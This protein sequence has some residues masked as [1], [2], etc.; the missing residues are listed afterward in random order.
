MSKKVTRRTFIK[1]AA[2]A[3][4]VA[5]GLPGLMRPGSLFAAEEG[6]IVRGG[7]WRVA[8]DRTTPS[9]DVH[10]VSE[11]F[12]CIGGMY[13]CLIDTHVD[14]ETQS[15]SLTPMLAEKWEAADDGKR[16]VFQLKKGVL[17]HD[18]SKFTAEVAKWNLDRVRNHP[19]SYL[20]SD[21]KEI[22][23][24]EVLA[25]DLIAVNLKAPSGSLLYNLSTARQWGGMVSKA[26][27]EKH[28]DDE[29]VRK[30][31]G[32]G[33]F[34]YKNW[35]VDE[36]VVLEKFPDYWKT[37]KDGKPLPY[38]DGMEEHYRPQ[39]NQAVV[40]LRAGGLDAVQFPA[41]R[42]V[43]TIKDDPDLKY[44]ELPPFEYQK[45]CCGFNSRRGPFESHALRQAACYAIDREK[46]VKIMG[47]GVARPHQFPWITKGQP[48][49]APSMWPDYSYNPEKA[50]ELLKAAHPKGVT[51]GLFVIAREPDTTLGELLKSMWDSVGIRTELKAIE[52]LQWIETMRQDTYEAGFWNAA[53]YPGGFIRPKLMSGAKGNWGQFKNAEVDALLDK[54]A[55]TLEREKRHELMAKAL[56]IVYTSAELT[57]VYA[58]TQAV[59]CNK[60]VHGL[61]SPW[62][63]LVAGEV[64]MG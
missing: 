11:Y 26:F 33:P 15:L 57:S 6:D 46:F 25:D 41:A 10:R 19:K 13:E 23:S 40:D 44:V 9:L 17:F 16:I 49:W 31:C 62:R 50:K 48:G 34:R 5:V 51:V 52:R 36:K 37:G 39:L 35:I 45:V 3:G 63:Y 7:I 38:L 58:I 21:L 29:L 14:P 20:A 55:K 12:T 56:K 43:P 47:Y 28:G 30:G 4:G 8:R 2:V 53:T 22:E 60:T 1:S 24:V 61:R 59:G 27:Q 54:H 64:W 18:G 42:D 32:T